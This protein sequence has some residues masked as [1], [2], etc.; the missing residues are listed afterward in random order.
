M[1]FYFE[2]R[3][4]VIREIAFYIKMMKLYKLLCLFVLIAMIHKGIALKCYT[5]DGGTS[6]N[7]TDD[8]DTASPSE[9]YLQ[10]CA[11]D[12][13]YCV[14]ESTQAGDKHGMHRYCSDKEKDSKEACFLVFGSKLCTEVV[15]C[16]SDG[17]NGGS[18]NSF[19]NTFV[20]T[21]VDDKFDAL[22][23]QWNDLIDQI[24]G[25]GQKTAQW[26]EEHK[27]YFI[28]FICVCVGIVLIGA[29]VHIVHK[30][31]KKRRSGI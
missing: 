24:S 25:W 12:Q 5:C 18:G 16:S 7:E 26:W 28:V 15:S 1:G 23:E 9:Q 8:C 31:M 11:S 4:L 30:T 29:I 20:N 17:C 22:G 13:L 21:T 14:K 10:E 19:A 6:E 2:L 3:F 27:V